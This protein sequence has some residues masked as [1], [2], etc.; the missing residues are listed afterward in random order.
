[1]ARPRQLR[2]AALLAVGFACGAIAVGG[3]FAAKYVTGGDTEVTSIKL[4]GGGLPDLGRTST[5]GV[6]EL[7]DAIRSYHDSGA[8]DSDLA[9]VDARAKK[10]LSK[11]LASW[12]GRRAGQV[13]GVQR[14]GAQVPHGQARD[15]ARHRRDVALQLRGPQ[16]GQL[17]PQARSRGPWPATTR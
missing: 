14:Q 10:A 12:Q 11:Q 7:P 17:Q 3:A 6:A 16:R 4:T 1:M 15:R 9:T 13:L 2:G 8:Y 5:Y